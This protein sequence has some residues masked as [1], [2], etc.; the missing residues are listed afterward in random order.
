MAVEAA[1]KV[2]IVTIYDQSEQRLSVE[3]FAMY[4]ELADYCY[5]SACLVSSSDAV[6]QLESIAEGGYP[7]VRIN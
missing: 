6:R 5:R 4:S 7:L 1:S 2:G 3:G